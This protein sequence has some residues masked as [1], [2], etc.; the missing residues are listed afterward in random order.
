MLVFVF[1]LVFVIVLIFCWSLS[2]SFCWSLSFS[3]YWSCLCLCVGLMHLH[4]YEFTMIVRARAATVATIP[5]RAGY[6]IL[7]TYLSFFS[8]TIFLT[9]MKYY[10]HTSYLSFYLFFF[11]L[12]TYIFRNG[13]GMKYYHHT[14]YLSFFSTHAIFGSIFLHIKVRES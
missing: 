8:Q 9:K 2:F 12:Y 10:Q 14:S 3:F 13:L 6:E 7:S 1:L 11:I 4:K 5:Q